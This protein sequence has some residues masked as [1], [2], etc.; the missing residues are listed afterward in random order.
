MR[1]KHQEPSLFN[2]QKTENPYVGGHYH[3][4]CPHES[5]CR[6]TRLE[7]LTLGLSNTFDSK[8]GR[9]Y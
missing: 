3:Q 4:L 8:F 7:D 9:S 2:S 5:T 6:L 1:V